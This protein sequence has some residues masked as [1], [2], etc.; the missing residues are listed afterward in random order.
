MLQPARIAALFILAPAVYQSGACVAD[1]PDDT[2]AVVAEPLTPG[3]CA[4]ACDAVASGNCD[5]QSQ[6]SDDYGGAGM[7]GLSALCDQK[8]LDC[9]AAEH[10]ANGEAWGLEYCWRSCE[11]LH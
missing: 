10:A 8:F 1:A 7:G 2:A 11:G 6:C 4:D 9:D 5:W 3:P